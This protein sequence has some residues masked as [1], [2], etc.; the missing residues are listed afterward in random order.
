MDIR[1]K[2]N[3]FFVFMFL[4]YFFYLF[5]LTKYMGSVKEVQVSVRKVGIL[6][7]VGR[8]GS[9]FLRVRMHRFHRLTQ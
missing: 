9:T 3:L 8:G 7:V 4:H 6:Q 1:N 2:K 5:N